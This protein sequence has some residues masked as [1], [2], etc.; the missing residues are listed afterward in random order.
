MSH[1]RPAQTTLLSFVPAAIVR[2]EWFLQRA[3]LF[4][5]GRPRVCGSPVGDGSRRWL[6][7]FTASAT[8]RP[9]S[10]LCSGVAQVR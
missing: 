9:A 5:L 6:L 8:V 2:R 10:T 1:H 4:L 3:T 7:L